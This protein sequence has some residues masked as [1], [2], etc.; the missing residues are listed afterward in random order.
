MQAF[1]PGLAG[2][3]ATTLTLTSHC[4]EFVSGAAELGVAA[5]G[6]VGRFAPSHARR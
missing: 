2:W 1:K 3:K 4:A 5:V 6:R